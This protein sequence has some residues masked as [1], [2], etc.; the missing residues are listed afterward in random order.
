MRTYYGEKGWREYW[1]VVC[2]PLKSQYV[3]LLVTPPAS[4]TKMDMGGIL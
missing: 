4:K 2:F 1:V 3:T